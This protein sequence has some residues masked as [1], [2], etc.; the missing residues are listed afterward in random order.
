MFGNSSYKLDFINKVV[1]VQGV[2]LM[3]KINTLPS[4]VKMYKFSA[5]K[6]NKSEEEQTV[7][8]HKL[9]NSMTAKADFI[10]SQISFAGKFR[11]L[12]KK[13]L[14]FLSTIASSLGVSGVI[15][16]KL[17]D[18]LSDFLDKKNYSSMGDFGG[19]EYIDE[20][21]EL[22]ERFSK[23]L[24]I[25]E[26]DTQRMLFLTDKIIERCDSGE[27]YFPQQNAIN[28]T[29]EDR[30]AEEKFIAKL[31]KQVVNKE[32]ENDK[33]LVDTLCQT[34]NFTDEERKKVESIINK[35]LEKRNLVTLKQLDNDDGIEANTAIVDEITQ[36]LN[37]SDY[38]NTLIIAEFAN[39]ITSEKDYTPEINPLDRDA[40]ISIRDKSVFN[41]IMKNNSVDFNNAKKLYLAL[42]QD[43]YENG[44][45]SVFDLFKKENR[46]KKFDSL[47]TILSTKYFEDIEDDLF[48][49]FSMAAKDL[50]KAK[51]KVEETE[52]KKNNKYSIECAVIRLLDEKF[53]FAKDD[54]LSLR[55]YF[56]SENL[57]LSNNNDAWK[58]AYEISE[59]L[60]LKGQSEN[61]IVEVI[62]KVNNLTSEDIDKYNF[63]YCMLLASKK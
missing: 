27:T 1:C 54:I 9:E 18:E 45:K 50:D 19:E 8:T 43:A 28:E 48:I 52:H 16:N 41:S 35:N 34:F 23:I 20:Q 62:N 63:E 39:R 46:G 2:V 5:S 61:K 6:K 58:A 33:K 12:D 30:I 56:S 59:I 31:I 44:F 22:A 53:N 26:Q 11:K 29:S 32:K 37:L 17:K 49:E 13:D 4:S 47:N 42:K 14:L 40:E 60:A 10:K 55:R 3:N 21:A 25:D 15:L 36:K 24:N 38:D 7:D 51:S 57:D